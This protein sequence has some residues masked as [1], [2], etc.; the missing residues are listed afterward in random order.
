M[1]TFSRQGL[2]FDVT[3]A[4]PEDGRVVILLHGWPE[5]R[6][7]WDEV[8]PALADAG[9]R[10]LAPDQRGY[11]PGARPKG[12]RAYKIDELE[13]DVLALADAAGADRFDVV[14][15]DWGAAVAWALA[16]RWP[17]RVR[18]LSA[19]SVP[20][21]EA[22]LRSMLH[23]KQVLH[24]WYMLFFQLPAVPE[25]LMSLG[26]GKGLATVLRR[27]GL[28]DAS[29]ERYRRRAAIGGD[30]TGTINWYR[31]IPYGVTA[32][33]GRVAVP[34]MFVYGGGD[35]FISRASA[36]AC[37]DWVSGSYRYEELAGAG[38]WLPEDRPADVARLLVEY[39]ATV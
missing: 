4:G 6:N 19:L 15:H 25:A 27:S 35:S 23:S 11:S 14:G 8:I 34:T 37:G 21:T 26:R 20:H 3:D 9:Y 18:S 32:R 7:C 17:D 13:A 12:R 16:G 5:D 38:H 10:V 33:L 31:A 39:L 28:G 1:L 2:T 36:A 24:S 29:V 22:F 30:M